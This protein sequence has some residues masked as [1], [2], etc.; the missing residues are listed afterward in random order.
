MCL[1][2]CSC[3]CSLVLTED[4]KG[5][6]VGG[7]TASLTS[8]EQGPHLS[9][10]VT[11][12]GRWRLLSC[13]CHIEN[14]ARRVLARGRE[15]ATRPFPCSCPTRQG[16]RSCRV[17]AATISPSLCASSFCRH[18]STLWTVP[19]V[20]ATPFVQRGSHQSLNRK[21]QVKSAQR[22][23]DSVHLKADPGSLVAVWP[24]G[25]RSPAAAVP[26]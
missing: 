15:P 11:R 23:L 14:A 13:L 4:I 21:G 3:C 25:L 18:L 1:L 6:L 24:S 9:L 26:I 19:H 22:H 8:R 10:V 16:P 5:T 2:A 7:H 12:L 20:F 17:R